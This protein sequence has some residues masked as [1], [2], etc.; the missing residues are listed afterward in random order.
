MRFDRRIFMGL[1]AAALSLALVGPL[2]AATKAPMPVPRPAA[3]PAKA[4]A[5]APVTVGAQA[6]SGVSGWMVVDLDTGE[7]LDQSEADRTFAPASVAKLPTAAFALDALGPDYRF[8]TQVLATGPIE[9]GELRGDLVLKGGGDPEL[10]TDSLLPLITALTKQG[11]SKVAGA[12]LADGSALPQ[13]SEITTA[14]EVDAAYNPSVSG[15]NLNYNRVHVKWDA[16]KGHELLAVEAPSSRLSSPV[17]IVRVALASSPDAPLFDVH[18]E[19]GHEVWQMA[20]RAYRGQAA[21][22]L[23]VKR[24]EAYAADVFRKLGTEK[25]LLFADLLL[26]EAPD[27]AEVLAVHES[28]PLGDIV[29]DMLKHSTNLTAEVTGSAATR[30]TGLAART[31][32]DSA[33][34]MNVWAAQVAGF[35]LHDPGFQLV[36]HSGLTLDS[37]VSPRRMIELLAALAE[38]EDRGAGKMPGGVA[39]YLRGYDPG[40]EGLKGLRVAAKT[41]TMSFVRGLAGYILTPEGRRLAFAVFSNDLEKRGEGAQ[42]VDQGWMGRA[43]AFER[44]LIRSWVRMADA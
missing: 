30:A 18:H 6:P 11:V 5:P 1:S 17:D 37:R 38:D 44:A 7:I 25:G 12:L 28:R 10:D 35:P 26:G 8:E 42:R 31:L 3:V 40:G 15:L 20:R 32:S 21:R 39:D 22:W 24:P 43:K 41:G 2:A 23:P 33:A 14:Q 34:V 29:R 4:A 19:D 9:N 27:G 36:N 16:R 13:V